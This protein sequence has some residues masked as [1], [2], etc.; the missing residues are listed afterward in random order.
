MWTLSQLIS[1]CGLGNPVLLIDNRDL[2]SGLPIERL[3][4][5][6]QNGMREVIAGEH[7]VGIHS[8]KI[9]DLKLDEGF[10]EIGR[11]PEVTRES[12]SLELVSTA[13]D[14]HA[15]LDENVH[16]GQN[17]REEDEAN[18]DGLH[19]V[20]SKIGIQRLVVDEHREQREDVEEVE[21][22]LSAL[23]SYSKKGCVSNLT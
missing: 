23:E 19:G 22:A 14:V 5:L 15:Q 16:R 12:V 10:G 17:I 20:E 18:N 6:R 1:S 21:L 13:Q 4:S 11:V 8:A 9:L 3:Q 7:R 2:S